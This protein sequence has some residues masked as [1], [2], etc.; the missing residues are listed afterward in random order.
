[1]TSRAIRAE[2]PGQTVGPFFGYALPF[3][4]GEALVPVGHPEAIRLTGRVLD[5]A[6]QPVPDALLEIWQA[7]TTGAIPRAAGSLH[8]DGYTFTGWGRAATDNVGRYSFTT[9]LPG[10][11]SVGGVP[12]I[13]MT[14]F[15][16]GLL[17]RLSTRIYLDDGRFTEQLQAEPF[18]QSLPEAERVAL[19]ATR[20]GSE[21]GF[22]IRLQGGN[23]TPFLHFGGNAG[24]GRGGTNSQS[25]AGPGA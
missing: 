2:T 21:Y 7:D 10:P 1:M 15:A 12:M 18:L 16:R 20:S 3:V 23:A 9:V 11:M 8:R 14:V 4:G 22:D 5:G 13:A 25:P 19:I 17:D 6:D 24:R